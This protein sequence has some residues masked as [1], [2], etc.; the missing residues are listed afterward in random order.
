[1]G[2]LL[3]AGLSRTVT[4]SDAIGGRMT[5]DVVLEKELT[6]TAYMQVRCEGFKKTLG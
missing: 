3:N 5:R 6:E 1:M 4:S 2:F